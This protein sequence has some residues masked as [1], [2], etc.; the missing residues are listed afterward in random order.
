MPTILQYNQEYTEL[1]NMIF[2]TYSQEYNLV[3]K[4][5]Y[6]KT[7]ELF[8]AIFKLNIDL[9][10]SAPTVYVNNNRALVN[11]K[12]NPD[13]LYP[14]AVRYVTE[15][16]VY[17]IERP[18]F[19]LSVDFKNA[20]ASYTADKITPVEIWIPWTV[21]VLPMT[22]I[23]A[24][25][26]SGLRLYFNDGPIQSL[27]DIVVPGYLP[28][29]YSDGRICWS[30]SFNELMSNL[31]VS[32]PEKIDINYL[33]SS[34]LNEYMMG[35]WNTDLSFTYSHV[36]YN[37]G[38][39]SDIDVAKERTPILALFSNSY[40]IDKD[41]AEKLKLIMQQSFGMTKRKSHSFVDGSYIKDS[42]NQPCTKNIFLKLFAFMSC[43]SLSDTLSFVTDLKNITKSDR[44]I[45]NL[46]NNA[47]DSS[48]MNSSQLLYAS[49]LP[50]KNT[51]LDHSIS[52]D[53]NSLEAIVI[54]NKT[55]KSQRDY[56]SYST[57]NSASFE[58][59]LSSISSYDD[60]VPFE[61]LYVQIYDLCKRYYT[62]QQDRNNTFV[63][64]I[65][66]DDKTISS[67]DQAY[68]SKFITDNM[69]HAAEQLNNSTVKSI[70]YIQQTIDSY[71]SQNEE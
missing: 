21:M 14:I 63:I 46:A 33:Y 51:C 3:R 53:H 43:L 44:T 60:E 35:G 37:S 68:L 16:N 22:D 42:N 54:L 18:P 47:V 67:Y 59:M 11:S 70:P 31:N 27:S 41:F 12:I 49:S 32:G 56:I 38:F 17:V 26:P 19:R 9:V 64:Q 55:Y 30:N 52:T 1:S 13:T 36:Q 40:S 5:V 6:S 58:D 66:A 71:G 15:N 34:I 39:L 45:G 20:R 62:D 61:R 4:T 65:N 7:N 29:S 8:P 69:K 28:N 57:L 23:I 48:Y 50:V 24:G 25:D 2:S 10:S